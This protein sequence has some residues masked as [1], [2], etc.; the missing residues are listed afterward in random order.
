MSF[1]QVL[2]LIY[3]VLIVPQLYYIVPHVDH[4]SILVDPPATN[5]EVLWPCFSIDCAIAVHGKSCVKETWTASQLTC[6]V[7]S[8]LGCFCARFI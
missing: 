1:P 4:N 8:G 3:F 6:V 7:Y 5:S 2:L